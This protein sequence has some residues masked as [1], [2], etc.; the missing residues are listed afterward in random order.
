[1]IFKFLV[2]WML[3]GFY[4]VIR[5]VI[6]GCELCVLVNRVFVVFKVL[7]IEGLLFKW[8]VLLICVLYFES[9]VYELKLNIVIGVLLKVIK[10]FL[11][12]LGFILRYFERIFMNCF[13]WVYWNWDIDDD[14]FI[15]KII[16]V[17]RV[18]LFGVFVV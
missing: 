5:M 7:L 18:V 10:V 1:M 6:Y 15:M 16:L 8:G 17:V 3:F 13:V 11:D 4:G 12:F 2:F 14:E 9:S